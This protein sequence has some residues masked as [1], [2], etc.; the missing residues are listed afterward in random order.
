[1]DRVAYG[2]R[3]WQ[4][5]VHGVIFLVMSSLICGLLKLVATDNP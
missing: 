4:K 5:R 1:M 2:M 3:Y